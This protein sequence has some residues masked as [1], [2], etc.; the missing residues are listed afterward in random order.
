MLRVSRVRR[1]DAKDE[2]ELVAMCHELHRENGLFTMSGERVRDMLRRAF[3][4]N[5]GI[6]GVIG[7]RGR[8]QGSIYLL[9][10][11]LW[12][13]DDFHLEELWNFVRAPFRKT[14]NL[15]EQIDFAKHC[16]DELG[17]PAIIGILS[18]VRTEAKVRIYQRQLGKPA[19]A[20]FVHQPKGRQDKMVAS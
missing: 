16:S 19:G 7:E 10:T 12:Y 17:I 1:A 9:L 18:N 3:A 20:F 11:Q 5:G 8:L 13:S 6:V 4:K 15:Q 14:N 2:D